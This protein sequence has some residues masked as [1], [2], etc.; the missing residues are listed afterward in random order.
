MKLLLLA[1]LRAL[2]IEDEYFIAVDLKNALE[3]SGAEAVIL[4]GQSD[5]AMKQ[6]G[7]GGFEIALVDINLHG[8]SAIPLADRLHGKNVPFAFVTGYDQTLIPT[9]FKDIPYWGKPFDSA[10]VVDKVHKLWKGAAFV[11]HQTA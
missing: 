4:S 6:I 11:E 7:E 3:E 1:G 9:R 2:V 5:A 8:V 10:K